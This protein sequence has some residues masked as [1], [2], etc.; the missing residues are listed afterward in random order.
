M[1]HL[2]V[3]P[4]LPP[5]EA[6]L[7]NPAL[8]VL[9]P[10]GHGDLF[11]PEIAAGDTVVIIDG[12]Y[13]HAAALRHK[14]IMAIMHRGVR[15]IGASSIGAL[16]ARELYPYGMC[17]VGTIYHAYLTGQITADD[18]VAVGQDP[19]TG[20]ALTWP[21]VTCRYVISLAREQR[22]I[23]SREASGLMEA[24]RGIYYPQRTAAVV[25]A[26]CRRHGTS[27]FIDWV[28]ERRAAEPHFGDIKHADALQA[29]HTAQYGPDLCRSVPRE[30]HFD[31]GYFLR[32]SNH[33]AARNIDGLGLPTALCLLYQQVFDPKFPEVWNR[34]L[35]QLSRHPADAGPGMPLAER[36][37]HLTGEDAGG[38]LPVHA[39]FRIPVDLRDTET[40]ARLL[41]CETGPDRM[42]ILRY[43]AAND[44]ARRATPG[45]L[46]ETINDSRAVRTL[47][48]LW[49]CKFS[50]LEDAAAARGLRSA[51]HAIDAV[52]VFLAG[53]FRD[54]A[55]LAPETK[56]EAA[57]Y[58]Y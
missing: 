10:V 48:G 54:Q 4:T 53:F 42:S 17:G 41:A 51:A 57:P 18:E 7:H 33:F 24:L 50:G 58:E 15:V 25:R 36:L 11:D 13:H 9:P 47:C 20:R 2:Y 6:L 28:D 38:T 34:H 55:E 23:T 8:R 30:R 31:T 14:E 22:V 45:F 40:V 5:E 49:R 35:E 39:A 1:I 12:V 46:P 29:V 3:G 27:A 32:W 56:M 16:R 44:D 19:D 21:L 26:V 52:K 43:L 37:A